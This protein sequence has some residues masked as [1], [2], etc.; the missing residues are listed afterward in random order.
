MSDHATNNRLVPQNFL[1]SIIFNVAAMNTLWL[2]YILRVLTIAFGNV[3]R[4]AVFLKQ[5]KYSKK[6]RLLLLLLPP[7]PPPLPAPPPPPP[8]FKP[9]PS[10]HLQIFLY[11]S[12]S[13][14]SQ[15]QSW[16]Y[17]HL[18]THRCLCLQFFSRSGLLTSV[19]LK[20]MFY[21][22]VVFSYAFSEIFLWRKNLGTF[23]PRTEFF[24][25]LGT[26]LFENRTLQQGLFR[27]KFEEWDL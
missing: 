5:K 17:N 16:L 1:P 26:D 21:P 10:G 23:C 2:C 6:Y 19:L 3:P 27:K 9:R 4:D 22:T 13:S 15:S 8:L 7:P 25:T 11:I 18:P 14:L 20:Y 24:G 12:V